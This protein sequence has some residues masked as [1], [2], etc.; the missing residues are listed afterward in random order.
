MVRIT[1]MDIH[2]EAQNG[3]L[4]V[5]VESAQVTGNLLRDDDDNVIAEASERHA[6]AVERLGAL[7][8]VTREV[9]AERDRL[10][11]L[12]VDVDDPDPEDSLR[13]EV[14]M[15]TYDEILI[16][17]FEAANRELADAG[18]AEDDARHGRE[19]VSW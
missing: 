13:L 15:A 14:A 9:T 17:L 4:V 1:L 11:R 3:N 5:D 7:N 2:P 16:P 10:A 6:R 19:G 18:I 12:V 8:L